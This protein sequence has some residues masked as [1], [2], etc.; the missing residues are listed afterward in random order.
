MNKAGE[1]LLEA[2]EIVKV[3]REDEPDEVTRLLCKNGVLYNSAE[4]LDYQDE[5]ESG[6]NWDSRGEDEDR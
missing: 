2:L 4:D 3:I 5:H 1:K 6:V